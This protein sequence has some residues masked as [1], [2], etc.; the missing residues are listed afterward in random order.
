MTKNAVDNAG[1]WAVPLIGVQ[2]GTGQMTNLPKAMVA[3]IDTQS[4]LIIA[5]AYCSSYCILICNRRASPSYRHRDATSCTDSRRT[6]RWRASSP[7][8]HNG[9][10]SSRGAQMGS[11]FIPCTTASTISLALGGA[12]ISLLASDLGAAAFPYFA[13]LAEL[14][15]QRISLNRT[16][17][18]SAASS[19]LKLRCGFS[20]KYVIMFF[21]SAFRKRR[22]R[23]QPFLRNAYLVIDA[24]DRSISLAPRAA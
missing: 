14:N 18:V 8:F 24:D 10:S 23:A 16:G 22:T 20:V 17:R 19:A 15:A 9:V 2:S 21:L 1:L 4:E 12:T 13:L 7:F 3:Y 6:K 11:F 5:R